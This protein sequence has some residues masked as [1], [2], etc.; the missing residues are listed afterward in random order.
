MLPSL[1]DIARRLGGK[2]RGGRVVAPGPGQRPGDRSLVVW[3]NANGEIGVH[4][5]RGQDWH[6]CQVF[7]RERCGIAPWTPK[8]K[9][10]AQWQAPRRER[11]QYVGEDLRIA[12]S[13]KGMTFPQFV[14][15]VTDLKNT[16][17]EAQAGRYAHEFGFSGAELEQALQAKPRTYTAD[18]RAAIFDI[19]YSERMQL[20]LRRTGSVDVDKQ[21]RE[22]ARRDRDNA[23]RR[24][25]RA[26]ARK[27]KANMP[28][29]EVSS[30]E[31]LV[32]VG[33]DRGNSDRVELEGNSDLVVEGIES[34][35]EVREWEGRKQPEDNLDFR[36]GHQR[37]S[38]SAARPLRVCTAGHKPVGVAAS[39]R[40]GL[41]PSPEKPPAKS[42]PASTL[43]PTGRTARSGT[44]PAG[45]NSSL[46]AIELDD[47][48]RRSNAMTKSPK[49]NESED[50]PTREQVIDDS[51]IP[52]FSAPLR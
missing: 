42:K 28:S 6:L 15:L 9:K 3:I 2:V 49:A 30:S 41:R 10:Q 1:H 39:T 38:A 14:V 47:E 11:N 12:R 19:T 21:G 29:I 31:R 43:R 48:D 34:G 13:R 23:K 8:P 46:K 24:A 51:S 32:V 26:A 33:T 50:M 20:G 4:S 35:E 17:S 27:A 40:S 44:P 16:G 45:Q 52:G 37:R 36:P 5:H 22:R 25:K 7:V 18:E